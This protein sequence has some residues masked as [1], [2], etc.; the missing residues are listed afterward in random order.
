MKFITEKQ[1]LV[2]QKFLGGFESNSQT[3]EKIA[4]TNLKAIFQDLTKL[5]PSAEDRSSQSIVKGS[6]QDIIVEEVRELTPFQVFGGDSILADQ[7]LIAITAELLRDDANLR[8]RVISTDWKNRVIDNNKHDVLKELGGRVEEVLGLKIDYVDHFS[9]TLKEYLGALYELKEN[10]NPNLSINL[11]LA[12]FLMS[13][14]AGILTVENSDTLY[15]NNQA[16]LVSPTSSE[17][18]SLF[19]TCKHQGDQRALCIV[20]Y[21]K[22]LV[23][24]G[25]VK[26]ETKRDGVNEIITPVKDFLDRVSP[27][28]Y[29]QQGYK[30]IYE[31]F[32]FRLES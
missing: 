15:L 6:V 26:A 21:F 2:S 19:N 16:I 7:V 8:G 24:K 14:G 18:E 32:I 20:Q 23:K 22:E 5:V 29:T 10:N 17:S 25:L 13:I 3:K 11:N 31:L 30:T 28:F 9:E 12:M 4:S 27:S 1:N